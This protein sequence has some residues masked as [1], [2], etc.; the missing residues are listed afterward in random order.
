VVQ[1]DVSDG[2]GDDLQ[3]LPGSHHVLVAVRG[4]EPDRRLHSPMVGRRSQCG[5]HCCHCPAQCLDDT[6]GCDV[7]GGTTHHMEL[8]ATLVGARVKVGVVVDNL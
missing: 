3:E 4:V 2:R 6:P 7:P 8:L 1:L 5:C